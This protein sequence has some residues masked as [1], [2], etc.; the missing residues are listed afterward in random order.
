MIS[1]E[2]V[3]IG[4]A[5]SSGVDLTGWSIVDRN[6][7]SEIL[8]GLL[9]PGESRHSLLTGS[10][11]QL[12]NKG[13]LIRLKEGADNQVHAVSYAKEDGRA[14]GRYVRFSN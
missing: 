12:G 1:V 14:E 6:N 9:A 5:T 13:G 8:S 2:A 4:N 7:N 11:A 3:V 10:T